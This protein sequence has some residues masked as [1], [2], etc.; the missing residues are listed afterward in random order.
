MKPNENTTIAEYPETPEEQEKEL[1][2]VKDTPSKGSI[3]VIDDDDT[4]RCVAACILRQSGYEV[5]TAEDGSEG[6][7]VLGKEKPELILLDGIM[8]DM[9]GFEVCRLIRQNPQWHDIPVIF[10]TAMMESADKARGFMVGGTDFITKPVDRLELLARIKMHIELARSRHLLREEAARFEL[11]ASKQQTRLNQIKAGQEKLLTHPQSITGLQA[12]VQFQPILEAGGDFYEI[13]R[14]GTDTYGALVVDISGHD[15]GT[16]YMTGAMKALAAS[17]I[18]ETL[19]PNE[20]FFM[21]NNTLMKFLPAE[22]YATACY[23]KFDRRSMNLEVISAGHPTPIVQRANGKVETVA[24]RGDVLGMFDTIRCGT[25]I[26]H[27]EPQD[28]F[29]MFTDGI[30]E[31]YQDLRTQR[32]DRSWGMNY[33][34]GQL[35]EKPRLPLQ[36]TVE[37]IVKNVTDQY[38]ATI[39]D[40]II[41]MGI[42]F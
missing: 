16:A 4:A 41:L 15:L 20:T 7:G 3:L 30:L 17:F 39:N 31:A 23:M 13:I 5:I 25:E 9:D 34:L 14:L 27:V 28:R 38:I 6:L 33:L 22:E 12:A 8:P 29:F 10:L 18:N 2:V 36:H 40:D 24:I 1:S 21:L 11:L 19:T 26:I 32:R 35:Q 37:K 42:E